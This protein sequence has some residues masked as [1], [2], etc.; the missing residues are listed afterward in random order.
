MVYRFF[1]APIVTVHPRVGGEHDIFSP[2][3]YDFGGSSPRGRGT[4]TGTGSAKSRER[5]IPAWAGN[6]RG[7]RRFHPAV[8]VHPR[9]GGEHHTTM[10]IFTFI[11]G[12][13]PRGRGTLIII[14]PSLVTTRFIPAWAGN[15]QNRPDH[16]A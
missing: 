8:S 4:S 15:I 16:G 6:I 12:S 14:L 9:V 3:E 11:T 13:S 5:F 7:R 1:E 10:D 2:Y